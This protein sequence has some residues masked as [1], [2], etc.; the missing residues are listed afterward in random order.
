MIGMCRSAGIGLDP[1]GHLV[2]VEAGEL[3]VHQ[4]QVGALLLRR[5][6]PFLAG[7][8]LDQLEAGA[9]QEVAQDAP[10]VLVVLDDQDALAHAHS[11]C[12]STRTGTVKRKVEPC[13]ERGLHPD[14]PAVQL[15]DPPGD[16]Q[17]EP[18][19]A[20]LPGAGAVGLLELLEDPLL[21]GLGDPGAGVGH[22]DDEGAVG[23]PRLDRDL[24]GLGELDRVAHQV[25]QH[26]GDPPLVAPARRQIGGH[27]RLEG[28][29]LLRPR[30][31]PPRRRPPARPPPWRSRR[32]TA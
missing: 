11:A 25:Q 21:V 1:A 14:A 22:R 12:R 20:L 15:H 26:L 16:R 4:D 32:A 2:A 24:A 10:V 28:E 18:G 7:H 13:A 3:D 9:R 30:A 27:D 23:D 5:R 29:L 8:R 17:P 19:A 6:D 31:T